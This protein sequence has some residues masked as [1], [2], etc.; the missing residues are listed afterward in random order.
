MRILQVALIAALLLCL[1]S[2]G[3]SDDSPTGETKSARKAHRHS[4]GHTHSHSDAEDQ[5]E[6]P[7]E[8]IMAAS[9]GR[10]P[11][12]LLG[13][14]CC[15]IVGVSLLGGSLPQLI[16]LSHTRM[17]LSISLIG[18]LMLGI[19]VLHLWPHAIAEL[20]D[21]GPDVAAT[22][23]MA[24]LIVMFL[25]LRMF[26]FHHHGTTEDHCGH[27]HSHDGPEHSVQTPAAGQSSEEQHAAGRLSW[28]GV[29]LGMALH[30]LIDGLALGA[31]VQADA[32]HEATGLLGVGTFLAVVLHKPLDSVTIISLMAASGWSRRSRALV[33]LAFSL[34]CPAGAILFVLGVREFTGQ[35]ALIVGFAL[36]V[37]AGVFMC[38][39]LSDLL[40][41]MEF[42]SHNRVRLSIALLAGIAIAWGIRFIEPAHAHSQHGETHRRVHSH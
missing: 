29:F 30:T 11:L 17:Q 26:H 21:H 12:V 33:N 41:E 35:Q 7:D 36:A 37:S 24:G 5:S 40:P 39:A 6:E 25:L 22:G 9:T 3:R 34:A 10:W 23:M 38:I 20:G 28:V 4:H 31:S 18:G 19:S 16:H 27:D 15:M 14:Y 32:L 1:S 8:S 13:L 42:H 2:T